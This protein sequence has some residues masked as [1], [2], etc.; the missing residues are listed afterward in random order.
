M[1]FELVQGLHRIAV[2]F[3]GRPKFALLNVLNNRPEE[4]IEP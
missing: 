3:I 2:E 4:R 1:S